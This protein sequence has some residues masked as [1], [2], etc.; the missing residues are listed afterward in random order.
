MNSC[1]FGLNG[2]VLDEVHNRLVLDGV[3]NGLVLDGVHNRLVLDGVH[4]CSSCSSSSTYNPGLY[5]D[6]G[7]IFFL[8]END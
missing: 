4:N 1:T 5:Q 8:Y 3:H 7:Y 6:S 2:L